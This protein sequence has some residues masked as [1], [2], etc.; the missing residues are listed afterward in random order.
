MPQKAEM[1]YQI[2]LLLS[3]WLLNKGYAINNIIVDKLINGAGIIF[4]GKI[5]R[6]ETS[7][8]AKVLRLH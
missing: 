1:Q 5:P 6:A 8:N 3:D 4:T 7:R 2:R